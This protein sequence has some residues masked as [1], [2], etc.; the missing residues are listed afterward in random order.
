MNKQAKARHEA[1]RKMVEDARQFYVNK[2]C[3][4]IDRPMKQIK[5]HTSR[6]IRIK[7]F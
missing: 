5:I 1:H 3:R 4:V 7:K 2:G 6:G